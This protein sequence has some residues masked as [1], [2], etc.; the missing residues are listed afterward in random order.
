MK[1]IWRYE[2]LPNRIQTVTIP[3]DGRILT[4]QTKGDNVPLM[5]VLVDPDMPMQERC[6]GIYTTN[7]AVPDEPGRYIDSFMIHEGMLEFHL[8]EMETPPTGAESPP[9]DV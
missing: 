9:E 8:F 4:V 7:T 3:F 1:T 2:L 5:W 6:L